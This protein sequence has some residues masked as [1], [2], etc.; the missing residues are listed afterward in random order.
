MGALL[1]APGAHRVR[2][3]DS[4][5]WTDY[6]Q[7][8]S[9]T[10]VVAVPKIAVVNNMPG[11]LNIHEVVQVKLVPQGGTFGNADL[12][13]NDGSSDCLAF[14]GESIDV[15]KTRTFDVTVGAN[16]SIYLG[17]GT[18]D[19]NNVTCSTY[20]PFFKR[21]WFTTTD[22]KM[23]SVYTIVNISSHTSGTVTFT[24]SGSYLNGTLKVVVTYEGST[25]GQY[26]FTV[27]T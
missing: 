3:G 22:F 5:G 27:T 10:V 9:A 2:V 25:I 4:H 11:T 23:H 16:Y 8:R 26:Y 7:V 18:W 12:L 6:S 1:P 13:T 19:M 14:P 21:T 20:A 24:I 17:I 15:G